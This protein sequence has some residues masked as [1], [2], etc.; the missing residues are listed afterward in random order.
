MRYM[1]PFVLSFSRWKASSAVE[2]Y[3]DLEQ[4]LACLADVKCS[5]RHDSLR[6]GAEEDEWDEGKSVIPCLIDM[7]CTAEIERL[8]KRMRSKP[9]SLTDDCFRGACGMENIMQHVR[10]PG[11]TSLVMGWLNRSIAEERARK[12]PVGALSIKYAGEFVHGAPDGLGSM[13]WHDGMHYQGGFAHGRL[14]GRGRIVFPDG[15]SYA[16][17]FEDGAFNTSGLYVAASGGWY[18]GDVLNGAA[19]GRGTVS[20]ADGHEFVGE[21]K[22][23]APYHAYQ[24]GEGVVLS[25]SASQ[26]GGALLPISQGR[27]RLVYEAHVAQWQAVLDAMA[28]GNPDGR[29]WLEGLTQHWWGWALIIVAMILFNEVMMLALNGLTPKPRAKSA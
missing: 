19:H 6:S 13:R 25:G 10:D 9:C 28:A 4:S 24:V 26:P 3:D 16:G 22:D 1:L 2:I 27:G 17:V 8:D 18:R 11:C 14:E 29:S 12:S 5:D 15:S 20:T 21:F 7:D 23:G